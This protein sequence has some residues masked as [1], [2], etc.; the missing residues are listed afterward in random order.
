[1]VFFH[2]IKPKT[3]DEIIEISRTLPVNSN[4]IYALRYNIHFLF[5]HI[6]KTTK[7]FSINDDDLSFIYGEYNRR[8]RIINTYEKNKI[9][10]TMKTSNPSCR[11]YYIYNDKSSLYINHK[12]DWEIDKFDNFFIVITRKYTKTG[13][14]KNIT[15]FFNLHDILDLFIDNDIQAK[16][17]L[18][19][20][21]V[22]SSEM[23]D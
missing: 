20:D 3:E 19:T 5:N 8:H 11:Y 22:E 12:L 9:D 10:D 1:M 18:T 2:R 21:E 15:V 4:F 7:S 17:F 23:W 13:T 16:L 14:D 6:K